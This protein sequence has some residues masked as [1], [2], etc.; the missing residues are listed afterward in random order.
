MRRNELAQARQQ[1]G[2]VF[3]GI[4]GVEVGPLPGQR[5]SGGMSESG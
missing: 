1:P 3:V 4:L 2:Q 5:Y